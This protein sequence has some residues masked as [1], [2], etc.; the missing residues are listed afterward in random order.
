MYRIVNPHREHQQFRGSI[1]LAAIDKQ[2]P[3]RE[4][5]DV[6]RQL[7]YVWRTR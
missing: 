6:C 2:L 5:T 3:Q 4:I 1:Q 7:G